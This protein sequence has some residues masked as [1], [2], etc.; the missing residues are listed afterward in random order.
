MPSLHYKTSFAIVLLLVTG[1]LMLTPLGHADESKQSNDPPAAEGFQTV[2]QAEVDSAFEHLAPAPRLLITDSAIQEVHKKI[3]QDPRL[4][5]YYKAIERKAD[6]LMEAAPVERELVGIR[7]LGVSREALNRILTWSFMYKMTGDSKYAERVEKEEVAIARFEDW[8]PQHFLDVAEMTLA[9]AI[10]YDTCKETFSRE[11]RHTLMEAIRD[12]GVK[13]AIDTPY[14]WQTNQANWNQVCWCGTL[15]GALAIADEEPALAQDAVRRAVNGIT[16]SMLSYSPDGTYTEGPAYWGYGTSFNALLIEALDNA[17]HTDFGRIEA[18]GFL[19]TLN[20]FEHVFGATGTVFNYPDS[21]AGSP[22][23]A[24]PFWFAD[25]LGKPEKA[26][27]ENRMLSETFQSLTGATPNPRAFDFLVGDRFAACVLL[28]AGTQAQSGGQNASLPEQLGFVGFGNGEAPV[29]LF[30]TEW[31]KDAAYLGIKAGEPQAPH[32]HM[33]IGGFVYEDRGVRWIVDLGPESYDDIEK[34]GMS[35]WDFRQN[36]D[37]WKIFRYSNFGH[38]VP[39][40]NGRLQRVDGRC[41]FSDYHMG[42][43]GE[44]SWVTIDLTPAYSG[45]LQYAQRKATLESDG[46][47]LIEDTFEAL[48]DK[49]AEI[50]RRII[51]PASVDIPNGPDS[52]ILDLTLASDTC[53]LKKRIELSG[54]IATAASAIPAHTD[55]E[56]DSPN[57]GITAVCLKSTLQPGARVVLAMK[58][59]TME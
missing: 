30:R 28:W 56:Y 35:L 6:R 51:T 41:G 40:V 1:L 26:W 14:W 2:G 53:T 4:L 33:D 44:A 19:Q 37:R 59:R 58:F 39:T 9:M 29:A 45:E 48:P 57:K 12:M 24:S 20:Y 16:W 52:G 17:L 3:E 22:F 10:G 54:D 8:H 21:G 7:L 55:K 38:S 42:R 27:N 23:E 50:E 18:N 46:T 49:T 43:T 25:K 5:E 31:N 36:S 47:L 11:N 15:F 34:R 32:G 13:T